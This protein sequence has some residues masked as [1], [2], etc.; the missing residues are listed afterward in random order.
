MGLLAL[1]RYQPK[2]EPDADLWRVVLADFAQLAPD[3]SVVITFDPD[4]PR[5]LH[6]TVIGFSFQTGAG[7]G[8]PAQVEVRVEHR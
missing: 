7:F 2:S 3:R 8:G 4:L 5:R 1:A 6:V